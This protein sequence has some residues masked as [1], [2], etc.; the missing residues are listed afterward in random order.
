MLKRAVLESAVEVRPTL[1]AL[2]L[3]CALPSMCRLLFA[4]H[5]L[6]FD[7]CSLSCRARYAESAAQQV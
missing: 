2:D 3:P 4:Q 1:L 6:K 7:H 5:G